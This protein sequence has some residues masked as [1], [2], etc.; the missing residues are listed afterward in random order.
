MSSLVKGKRLVLT[1]NP[2]Y[3]GTPAH[4][5][6]IVFR[7]ERSNRASVAALMKGS[8]SIAE[9]TPSPQINEALANDQ[10]PSSPVSVTTTPSPL[11][12]QLVF[13]LNDPV[14]GDRL[15]RSALALITDPGQLVADSVGL[16]DP[17]SASSASR[18]FAQG[19]PGSGDEVIS[20]AAYDPV[21]AA[22]LLKSLG[23]GPDQHGTMRI[24]GTGS[25]LIFTI[26]G[27]R[28]NTV[29]YALERQ[30]QAEWASCGIGLIIH[31]VSLK[32]LLGST[33][34]RGRYQLALAPFVMPA[35]P[36]WNAVIY[37]DSVL[38]VSTSFPP[39]LRVAVVQAAHGNGVFQRLLE[40]SPVPFPWKQ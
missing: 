36:T 11:L 29:I 24:D 14:V 39:N 21:Q 33:L 38:P 16:V 17:Y 4:L 26:T 23:Y 28:G 40:P 12:W 9:V 3:W 20:P 1:R 35:F 6:S 7:V 34:P 22:K 32:Y 13:N 10:G 5:Q 18:V 30:L 27:P 15:M 8:V 31:N 37:T 19:Q 25:R 2:R